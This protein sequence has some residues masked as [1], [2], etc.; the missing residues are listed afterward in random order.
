MNP[1]PLA[2]PGFMLRRQ[3]LVQVG[4]GVDGLPLARK[5]NVVDPLAASEPL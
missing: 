1:G 3:G 2:G 5:P 4:D